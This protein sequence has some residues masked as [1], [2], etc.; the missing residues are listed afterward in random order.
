MKKSIAIISLASAVCLLAS[1][2]AVPK[3]ADILITGGTVEE[4]LAQIQ[5]T[6]YTLPFELNGQKIIRI[7]M[8]FPPAAA[9][10]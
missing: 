9:S 8:N 5:D 6:H 4:A 3:T 1:C 7:G 2:G 10:S